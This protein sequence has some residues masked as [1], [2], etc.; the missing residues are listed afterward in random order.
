MGGIY[1]SSMTI[2][3]SSKVSLSTWLIL[4]PS[5]GTG[6]PVQ[7]DGSI[8]GDADGPYILRSRINGPGGVGDGHFVDRLYLSIIPEWVQVAVGF[9]GIEWLSSNSDDSVGNVWRFKDTSL[10]QPNGWFHIFAC[11][12]NSAGGVGYCYVNGV[13]LASSP[14]GG[15]AYG[16]FS[17]PS[18]LSSATPYDIA[19]NGAPI[20]IPT[21][22][23]LLDYVDSVGYHIKQPALRYADFQMWVGTFID[24]TVSEN[25]AKFVSIKD[26]VGTPV[27]PAIAASAFG[28]QTFLHK[29][30]KDHFW[31]NLGTGGAFIKS[32]TIDN[33][34]PAPSYA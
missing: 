28:E 18:D 2:P 23:E 24:P 16:L 26:G 1:Q 17:A 14:P 5:T 25:F 32:G 27:D 34:T 6:T 9:T 13:R 12:D 10:I 15:G 30:D 3:D 11:Q 20:G 8:W 22:P 31:I 19:L 21:Q 33:F 4:P 7:A 29:G